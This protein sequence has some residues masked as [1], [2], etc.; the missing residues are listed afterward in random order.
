MHELINN[1]RKNNIRIEVVEDRLKVDIP[2]E[3]QADGLLQQIRN[4][5]EALI[6]FLKEVNDKDIYQKIPQVAERS[7]YPLSPAQKRLYFLHE[8]DPSSLAYNMPQVLRLTGKVEQEKM[9]VAFQK[10]MARHEMLRTTFHQSDGGPV[11]KI[12][13]DITFNIEVFNSSEKDALAVFNGFIRPFDLQKGPLIRVALIQT[14]VASTLLVVDLHHIISDGITQV[15][16]IKDFMAFYNNALLSAPEIQYKDY[17]IWQQN[18]KQQDA[19]QAQKEFWINQF[20]EDIDELNLP[21]DFS[22]P[23]VIKYH[24][25]SMNFYLD[26]PTLKEL[27]ELAVGEHVTMYTLLLAVFNILIAK[28]SNQKQIVIGT[29]VAGRKHP[30]VKEM[31]GLFVNTLAIK[32]SVDGQVTFREFL[33]TTNLHIIKCLGNQDYPLEDLIDQLGIERNTSRNPLFDIMF[34]YQNF[35][36]ASFQLPGVT[37]SPYPSETNISQ[38]DLTLTAGEVD[39]GVLLNF[40]YSTDLFNEST[41]QQFSGYFKTLVES[42]LDNP[43]QRLAELDLMS[44]QEQYSLVHQFDAARIALPS[45]TTAL[46]LMSEHVALRP[47][48]VALVYGD[49]E[50]TYGELDKRSNQL[51]HYLL[52]QGLEDEAIVGVMVDRSFEM[53]IS[54]LGIMKAGGAYLPLDRTQPRERNVVILEESGCRLL[55][56]EAGSCDLYKAAVPCLA[57]RSLDLSG[58]PSTAVDLMPS[59]SQRAYVIYTSGSTGVPKGVEIVHATLLNLIVSQT[60]ELNIS[61]HDRVLQF[62]NLVFDASVEQLWL[63]LANGARSVLVS[64]DIILDQGAFMS[65]IATKKVT[66]LD[67][68]PTYLESIGTGFHPELRCI[69][70]AGEECNVAL[71]NELYDKYIVFN[72]YGPTEATVT[73]VQY[74]VR[75][76]I[77]DIRVPIGRPFGNIRAYVLGSEGDLLAKGV[78]GELYIAGS[79]LAKGYLHNA[80]LTAERFLPDPFFEGEK[81]YRTG[82]LV[83]WRS[84][85]N[86]EF[87]GRCDDQ[88]KIRGFRMELGEITQ[89]LASHPSLH[90]VSVVTREIQDELQLVAYYLS[91]EQQDEN[92]LKEYLKSR[93]PAY[94][95]PVAYVH[96]AEMPLTASGKLNR[97]ALPAPDLTFTS[98]YTPAGNELEEQLVHIWSEILKLDREQISVTRSFF[99]LGGHSLRAI[100][101]INSIR[102]EF[103]LDVPLMSVF[104]HQDIR[105]LGSYM[106]TLQEKQYQAILPAPSQAYYPL[107]SAQKRLY[108]LHRF[109]PSSLAY[110]MPEVVV[111]EGE[112]D[113]SRLKGAFNKLIARHESLRTSFIMKGEEPVQVVHD[114]MDFNLIHFGKVA[115]REEQQ[116]IKA[117]LRPFALNSAPLMRAGLITL[118]SDTGDQDGSRYLLIFDMHHIITDGVS[119]N[120]LVND[121]MSLYNGEE[122]EAV[123]LH[124]KDYAVWQHAASN[125]SV[126]ASHKSFWLSEY[127]ELP[128]VLELP[129]DR[130]RPQQ[131]SFSGDTYTFSLDATTFSG[132]K[133]LALASEATPYMLF[134]S[135]FNVFLSKLSNH[136]DVVVGT[137]IAG[138]DHPDLQNITGV[139][140]NTLAFRNYPEGSKQFKEFLK[141]VRSGAIQGFENQW[142]P[143]E[144]L[145]DALEVSR[146]PGRNPLF[147]AMFSY[148]N[149]E[150]TSLAIPGLKLS[151]YEVDHKVS[152]VDLSLTAFEDS[153]CLTLTFE[154]ATDL[155]DRA[156]IERFSG[157]FKTLVESVLDNPDQRLAELDLMSSQEQYSLVHQFDASRIALPSDTTALSLMNE[158]VALRPDA[159]ALVYG[160]S[161]LTYGELDKRSNQLA[162]YLLSQGLEDEAIVGVM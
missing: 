147:D 15:V 143:F 135:L 45:D 100:T 87:L 78:R 60:Q 29:P 146:D 89:Q 69:V 145:V 21:S 77:T 105:S 81:M 110:N 8:L 70:I 34:A 53:V 18:E 117:F 154:Y 107:S 138:R 160:D 17:V 72:G 156:T 20:K 65:Y 71:V 25:H 103:S 113:I 97:K 84:D 54:L 131:S 102:S 61:A 155:F 112:L 108:F 93:L 118:T 42:V 148:Q 120:L 95:V 125:E 59:P 13:D 3:V 142:Y 111:L 137:P 24:G 99:E 11:Q 153:D 106:S 157:Y 82:D 152:M 132:L 30:D 52:S 122:L 47:G 129:T 38:F 92:N 109:D 79:C 94:M 114:Q 46:S 31:V 86:L 90:E 35:E 2:K 126:I 28:L 14:D 4:N 49:S 98:S 144:A 74:R 151:A 139:F 26:V 80:A 27:K 37:I 123:K 48:A 10:L 43:D 150:A 67:V 124:Y 133:A 23:P 44:S 50:L 12:A 73:S 130:P 161:E 158:H 85:G 140:I 33:K 121:F 75:D 64:R 39:Q 32:S 127:K 68:T 36:D 56:T 7:Y 63:A 162:H 1:L 19:L 66:Y 76:K 128:E 22:R 159:V 149:F 134:L 9:N 16:L 58:C 104:E 116:L 96:L 57:V 51:A 62:A 5:K 136:S 41:I 91:D 141:E 40:E 119:Q 55:L 101:M 6:S 88:V 83:K 115:E